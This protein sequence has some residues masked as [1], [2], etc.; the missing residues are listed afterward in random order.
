MGYKILLADDSVTVQKIITLTFSDEGVDVLTV[1][2]GDEA[3]SRLQYMRPALVMADVS[4]PGKNG[5]E[6]CEYVKNHPDMK[7]TPV[8]LLV[9]AFEPFDDERARRIG[10]DQHLTKPF[11]SIRTLI[12]TVKTLL[13]GH[14]P[15]FATGSLN[16]PS[17]Q[18]QVPE[19]A[20]AQVAAAVVEAAPAAP[21]VHIR[22]TQPFPDEPETE[23]PAAAEI[24][25][26]AEAPQIWKEEP[27]V[28]AEPIWQSEPVAEAP[29]I[30]KE[31]PVVEFQQ[32]S[33]QVL[34]I[35]AEPSE[36]LPEPEPVFIAEAP[37]PVI[38]VPEPE[39]IIEEAPAVVAA[40]VETSVVEIPVVAVPVVE[41]APVAQRDNTGD[42]DHVLDLDDVLG[43][44]P[45]PQ[46][47]SVEVAAAASSVAESTIPQTVI[48]EIV[49]RVV[50]QLSEKLTAQ[51]A[52]Q[53][54]PEV[55]GLVKRQAKQGDDNVGQSARHDD[56][57]LDLD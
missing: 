47:Q 3:I 24:E 42:L 34:E 35:E 38:V 49:N 50:A 45:A 15:K 20:K 26:I 10:A 2:N 30:W 55:A 44:P 9:P 12:T 33:E 52:A 1:S 22:E 28:E 32:V 14:P 5:Y 29:Q 54:A 23:I 57:L 39:P 43:W 56:S 37:A 21:V 7:D 19:V 16:S 6:I 46:T 13:E 27:V 8:V 36:V 41:A 48:D 11:Q 25:E 18:L 4:I 17:S 31:E 51:L 53:L 40:P